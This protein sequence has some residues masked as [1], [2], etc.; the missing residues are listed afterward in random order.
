MRGA[1]DE[2][3]A[4]PGLPLIKELFVG[5]HESSELTL[6]PDK[7]PPRELLNWAE[8]QERHSGPG[9]TSAW[10]WWHSS[11]LDVLPGAVI[12]RDVE[13]K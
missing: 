4:Q 10:G 3:T 13:G 5:G 8:K 11:P 6:H 7:V 1:V 9:R 2:A 12:G